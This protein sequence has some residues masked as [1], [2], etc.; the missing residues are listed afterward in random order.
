MGL[1]GR[2][3]GEGIDYIELVPQGEVTR[4]VWWLLRIA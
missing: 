2:A 1:R 3:P 4:A